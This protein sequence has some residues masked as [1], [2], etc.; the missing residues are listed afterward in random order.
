MYK[1][2]MET[3]VATVS[4]GF[5]PHH[6][7]CGIIFD[8]SIDAPVL[9]RLK[10]RWSGQRRSVWRA[11]SSQCS[12]ASSITRVTRV[13]EGY[14][15]HKEGHGSLGR[16][17]INRSK[18][19]RAQS[20]QQRQD[21]YTPTGAGAARRTSKEWYCECDRAEGKVRV[22]CRTPAGVTT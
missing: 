3:V 7:R 18:R 5:S 11:S 15:Q 8:C 1:W 13:T 9:R 4:C 16:L 21:H 17:C 19:D 20:G 10:P 22:I 12:F 2:L 6:S 14:I